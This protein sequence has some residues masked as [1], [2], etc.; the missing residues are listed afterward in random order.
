MKGV[1]DQL[2]AAIKQA[3]ERII[4]GRRTANEDKILSLYEDC[5]NVIVRG[6][7]GSNV[8]FGNKLWLGEN[9]DRIIV[10][11]KLYQ[12][13]PGDSTLATPALG[14]L[15]DEQKRNVK[16]AWG[17]RGLTSKV[18]S[19]MLDWREIGNGLCPRDVTELS[20]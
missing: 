16:Q 3:H 9:R 1:L 15:L 17:D 6:K 11:Y 2:P 19:A 13:T 7:A 18:N 20:N 12:D 8:E 10:D 4:G 14:R 5:V